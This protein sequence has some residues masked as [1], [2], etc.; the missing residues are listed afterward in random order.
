MEM[1]WAD[2]IFQVNVKLPSEYRPWVSDM[3]KYF[4]VLLTIHVLQFATRQSPA[5]AGSRLFNVN[6]WKL[7][8]FVA[9]GVTA[10]HLV[11]KRIISFRFTDETDERTDMTALYKCSFAPLELLSGIRAWIKDR[12]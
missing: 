3:S 2:S 9:L 6:F 10:Y 1:S 8:A 4:V 5:A 12:L 11:F 7:I